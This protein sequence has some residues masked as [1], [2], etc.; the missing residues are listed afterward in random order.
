MIGRRKMARLLYLADLT[1][2]RRGDASIT[3]I[4]W[5]WLDHGSFDDSL[6][7]VESDLIDRGVV[8]LVGDHAE[9]QIRLIGELPRYDMAP[10]DLATLEDVLVK[11]ADLASASLADLSHQSAPV[12]DAQGRGAGAVLDLSLERTER[13]LD[14]LSRRMADVL[15]RLPEQETDPGVFDEIEQEMDELSSARRRATRDLLGDDR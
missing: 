1:A 7:V 9:A 4:E 12:R 6:R 3:G 5:R 14:D 8:S 10:T 13:R 2:V 15:R 11:Y